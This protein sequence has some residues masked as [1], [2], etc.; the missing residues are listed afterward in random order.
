MTIKVFLMLKHI[1]TLMYVDGIEIKDIILCGDSLKD[2]VGFAPMKSVEAN[3]WWEYDG[4]EPDLSAP[5]L[6]GRDV[7]L[8]LAGVG[9]YHNVGG[10]IELLYDGAYHTFFIAGR[11]F[12]YRLASMSGFERTGFSSFTLTLKDDFPWV[13]G[14]LSYVTPDAND[15]SGYFGD[16]DGV[17]LRKYGV[18][19]LDGTLAG[20][21]S[22]PDVKANLARDYGI[23][24]GVVYDN[25]D[26]V[27][28]G[29]KDIVLKCVMRA[30]NY[31]DFWQQRDNLL[32]DL[33]GPGEHILYVNGTEEELPFYY[34][35]CSSVEFLEDPVWWIFD[36]TL[37]VTKQRPV[38]E[39]YAIGDGERLL[40]TN[41][42]K[43]IMI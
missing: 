4:I 11:N 6:S 16:I 10:L 38:A 20:I 12:N 15:N 36:L 33:I 34:K 32:H 43:M 31:E 9:A 21:K 17:D 19:I 30:R 2:V 42:N 23:I 24:H 1:T 27:R 8:N 22:V 29:S 40:M 39:V 7:K 14:G 35:S 5:V 3:D 18:A 37:C 13:N 28:F 41:D 25:Y 26:Y